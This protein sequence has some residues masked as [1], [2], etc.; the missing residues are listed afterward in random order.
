MSL[1]KRIFGKS[2]NAK[3]SPPKIEV[4][5]PTMLQKFYGQGENLFACGFNVSELFNNLDNKYPGLKAK[6][7]DNGGNLRTFINIYINGK[8]I[9][10]INGVISPLRAGDKI[11]IISAVAGG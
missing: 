9:N 4:I 3:E 1:L 5:L 7:F 11:E 8:N 2:R 6:I 10:E